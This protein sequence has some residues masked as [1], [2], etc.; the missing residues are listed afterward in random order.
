MGEVN[1]QRVRLKRDKVCRGGID[2]EELPVQ[3]KRRRV[4][5]LGSG[6]RREELSGVC[7]TIG[8]AMMTWRTSQ[9][10]NHQLSGTSS[11]NSEHKK[12][13]YP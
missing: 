13:K 6:G 11:V 5:L 12:E 2:E 1:V 4:L 8:Q 7:V 3:R 10:I 9:H